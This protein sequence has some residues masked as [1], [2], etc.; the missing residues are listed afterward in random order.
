MSL[1]DRKRMSLYIY[2]HL[3]PPLFSVVECIKSEI[4]SRNAGK[5]KISRW[6]K[7]TAN[8]FRKSEIVD[9]GI[10]E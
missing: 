2:L 1:Y 9:Y 4:A 7:N 5:G 10:G 6:E 8:L 3:F